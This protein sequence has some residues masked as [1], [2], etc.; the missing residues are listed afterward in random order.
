MNFYTTDPSGLFGL[1]GVNISGKQSSKDLQ[2]SKHLNLQMLRYAD[3]EIG[4][5]VPA[6]DDK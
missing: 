2:E 5:G 4:K 1:E 3:K 6:S